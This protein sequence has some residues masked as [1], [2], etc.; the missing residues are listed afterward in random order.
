ME[1]PRS[2]VQQDNPFRQE[3]INVSNIIQTVSCIQCCFKCCICFVFIF[4]D[5]TCLKKNITLLFDSRTQSAPLRRTVYLLVLTDEDRNPIEQADLK[6]ALQFSFIPSTFKTGF[7]I[8][9]LVTLDIVLL[10]LSIDTIFVANKINQLH[11]YF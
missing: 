6:I 7:D 8:S 2:S 9:I 1:A 4:S 5:K 3:K 10:H 11:F